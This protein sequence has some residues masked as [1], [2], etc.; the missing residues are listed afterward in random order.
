VRDAEPAAALLDP[1]RQ[2]L[3]AELRQPDS[4]TGL[5]RRLRLPRQRLNY[6]LRVLESAG[7]VELVEERRKGNCL[8]R[9]VRATARSFVISPDALGPLGV[10]ADAAPDRLSSAYL[11]AAAG[12]TIR[13]VGALEECA[14]QEQKRLATLTLDGEV[15]FAS[16]ESRA[17]FAEELAAAVARLSAKYHDERAPG[18]RRFRLL[19]AVHPAA[20]EAAPSEAAP[21][22]AAPSEAARSEAARSEAT[23]PTGSTT[24]AS[25][26]APSVTNPSATKRAP[27]KRA[28]TKPRAGSPRSEG[29]HP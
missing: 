24:E 29:R 15:R 8:E 7:L 20:S 27:S 16:A 26:T 1:V 22:E 6:H 2:R 4:A 3:L 19:A 9:V 10:L 23:Q 21:S 11:L 12:R 17:A 28:P 18:G 13:E 5:A 14:R 25:V